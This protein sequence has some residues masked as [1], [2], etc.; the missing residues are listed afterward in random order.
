MVLMGIY[1]GR[2]INVRLKSNP[3]LIFEKQTAL[4]QFLTYFKK[5]TD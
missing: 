5:Q 4:N 1:D 2:P 3:I